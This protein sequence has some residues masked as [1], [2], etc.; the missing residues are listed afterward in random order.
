VY[1]AS[2]LT[3]VSGMIAASSM[4]TATQSVMPSPIE[5]ISGADQRA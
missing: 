5:R 4:R 1:L 2:V 3:F